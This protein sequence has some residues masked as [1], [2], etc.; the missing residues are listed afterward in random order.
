MNRAPD[1]NLRSSR[2]LEHE[3][4]GFE[5]VRSKSSQ[6]NDTILPPRPTESMRA[7]AWL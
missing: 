1:L 7:C 4:V 2:L 3:V 6:E 5:K